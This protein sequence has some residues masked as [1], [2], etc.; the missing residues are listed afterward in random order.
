MST[1][2]T[3][4][5]MG[6]MFDTAGECIALVEK[7]RP[8]WQAGKLNAIGGHIEGGES[9]LQCVR[10]EFR[11][12]TGI[13]HEDWLP[14]CLLLHEEEP[15]WLLWCYVAFTDEVVNV[16]TQTDEQIRLCMVSPELYEHTVDNLKW[17][18][19]MA[20]DPNVKTGEFSAVFH[21]TWGPHR[22]L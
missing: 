15:S 18:I 12:E 9:S 7:N 3:Y 20:L 21:G 5:A 10:R 1:D 6:F 17:L 11:E 8:A 13:D 16:S 19:P 14:F 2:K 4:Y 22:A